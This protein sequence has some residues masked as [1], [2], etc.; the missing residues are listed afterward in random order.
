MNTGIRR[1]FTLIELLVVI[2]IIAVLIALLLPAVQAAR[3]AARRAQCTNNLKQIGLAMHNY[4]QTNNKFPQGHS[5]SFAYTSPS[6][7][8]AGWTEW[9][10]QAEMLGYIEAGNIY[11]AI[12]FSFCGGYGYG[13][14]CNVS[15]YTAVIGSFMCPSDTN[16]NRGGP[17]NSTPGGPNQWGGNGTYP[18]NINSYRGSIGTTT[19][20]GNAGKYPGY[21]SCQPD[22]FYL[23]SA[24][25]SPNCVAFSTGIFA[26]WVANGIQDI[27]DGTSNTVAFA[28]SLVGDNNPGS[29]WNPGHV[30]NS[31]TGVTAAQPAEAADALSL[32][33][34][35][36]IVPAINACT[37]AYKAGGANIS[38]DNGNRWGW[39]AVGMTLFN[40]VVPPNYAPWNDC[41]DGCGGC[42]P[43]DSLFANAQS[44]HPGGVNV[45]MADGSARFIKNSIS[46]MTW[47]QLG[48]RSNGDVVSSDS[49]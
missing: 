14:Y 1:G 12:N 25:G 27:T 47:M 32:S 3:E 49:Y 10:A 7:G 35:N 40:T 11:N 48:T 34:Q 39:G 13:V 21:N 37:A 5:Q 42:S 20:N 16:V 24:N 30:N 43:D 23:N 4:H 41:R 2:A 6:K 18:P 44:N 45:L 36:V 15:A 17:P 31:I 46:P 38:Y 26:Y 29:S 22:P 9:S 19:N 8:Y 28:E 33:W